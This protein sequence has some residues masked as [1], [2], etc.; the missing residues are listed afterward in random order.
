MVPF[1][2]VLNRPTALRLQKPR[3]EYCGL[4]LKLTGWVKQD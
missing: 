2:P 1:V 4:D 3:L